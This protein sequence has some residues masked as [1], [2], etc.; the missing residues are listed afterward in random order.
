MGVL[1]HDACAELN[2]IAFFI[3]ALECGVRLFLAP[4][5]RRAL[6]EIPLHPLQALPPLWENWLALCIMWHIHH[7]KDLSRIE[8]K[9]YFGLKQHFDHS[10][11]YF[12][13]SSQG[14]VM[15]KGDSVSS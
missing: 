12:T 14:R 13:T 9:Y 15:C 1:P 4:F 7:N 10:G 6:S 5:I 3:V 11:V 8:L 2:E